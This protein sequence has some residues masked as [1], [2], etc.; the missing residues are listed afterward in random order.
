MREEP[1]I[2]Q[3]CGHVRHDEVE[4]LGG[5]KGKL[6]RDEEWVLNARHDFTLDPR[7]RQVVALHQKPFV[8]HFHGMH[9]PG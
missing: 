3:E 2:G 4:L 1:N 5:L 9:A 6:E 8:H 7:V